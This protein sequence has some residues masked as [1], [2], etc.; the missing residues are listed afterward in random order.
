MKERALKVVEKF[1]N[2][3]INYANDREV[4]FYCDRLVDA[5]FLN[6]VKMIMKC[7]RVVVTYLP[8]MI[9]PGVVVIA[10]NFFD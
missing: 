5:D 6:A 1:R 4:R 8:A 10:Y 2:V 3:E 7:D 9:A